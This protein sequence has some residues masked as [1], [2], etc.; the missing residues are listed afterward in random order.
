MPETDPHCPDCGVATEPTDP[1]QAGE[2]MTVKLRTRERRDGLL[3]SLGMR[4][5]LDVTAHVCPECGLVR[6]YADVEE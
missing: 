1:V 2:A 6:W 3:G 5:R 4:E